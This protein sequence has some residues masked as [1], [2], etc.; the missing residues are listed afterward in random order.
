MSVDVQTSPGDSATI[1]ASSS[2][3]RSFSVRAA[4]AATITPGDYVRITRQDGADLLGFVE[5]VTHDGSGVSAAGSLIDEG[6]DLAPVPFTDATA[7]PTSPDSVA[8]VVSGQDPD[9]ELGRLVSMPSVGVGLVPHRLNRHTFWCGQS[10]SGK[11]YALGVA[12]ERIILRTRLPVVVFDPNSDF[13]KLNSVREGL[14][15]TVAAALSGRSVR[16]LRPGEGPDALR[17]RFRD[18]GAH[19]KAAIL[20]LDPVVD[21]G[22]YNALLRLAPALRGV[23]P[24]DIPARMREAGGLDGEA[25]AQRVENLG[26]LEW[27]T[28]AYEHEA[29][30]DVIADRPAA[31]V[32]DLG[33]FHSA[34]EQLVVALAVLEDLWA[35]REERRPILIVVDE[36]HNLCPPEP[37]T[38]L[39]IAVR[40]RIIQI[41]AEGRKFGLWLLLSTQRPSKVHRGIVSQCDNATVMRMN[42]PGDLAELA[43][44]FGFVPRSML[45]QSARFRQGEALVAGGFVAMPSIVRVRD[46]ITLE[47]GIDVRVP[48]P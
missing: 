27:Q 42:S 22:E 23:D 30:T 41:A 26:L 8:R 14:D 38:P 4:A 18:M 45:A 47:G 39:G 34:D 17:V 3:G 2:D 6:G 16:V 7:A 36:A 29:A 32:L 20:R 46:R 19:A 37:E 35:R 33:S 10:G 12:L 1:R 15:P 44:L 25:L 13:V 43:D 31:T 28:W 24:K 5:D 48:M 40:D 11:T 21:R 9:L